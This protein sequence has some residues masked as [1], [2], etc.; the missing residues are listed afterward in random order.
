M[1]LTALPATADGGIEIDVV[2]SA[3]GEIAVVP[4]ALSGC[5]FGPSL[6]DVPMLVITITDPDEGAV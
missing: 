2:T 6:V 3:N 4:L 1:P 5:V